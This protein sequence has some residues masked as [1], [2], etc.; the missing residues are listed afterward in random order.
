M[1]A[2][3]INII[4]S[5]IYYQIMLKVMNNKTSRYFAICMMI[6]ISS[7][8]VKGQNTDYIKW[9]LKGKVKSIKESSFSVKEIDGKYVADSLEYY[10]WNEFNSY[11]NKTVDTK[12]L[13]NG[14]S[15]KN[16]I[17]KYDRNNRRSE[18]NQYARD[19]KLIRT[20]SYKYDSNGHLIEDSSIEGNGKPGKK[21][22]YQYDEKW[23]V[24]EDDSYNGEGKLQKK[25]TYKYDT[26]GN[27][28]E[29]FRYN[30]DG[31]LEKKIFYTYDIQNNIVE[32]SSYKPDGKLIWEYS[33]MY[34]YD[35]QNN[36]IEKIRIAGGKAEEILNREVVYFE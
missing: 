17:Y 15:D 6:S 10:Y 23:N 4:I 35:N 31:I 36:W 20:I 16:Y 1:F 3:I 34:K 32:E 7:I 8:F 12:F 2:N 21:I 22:A 33:Y 13:P 30:A 14:I 24:I 18:E 28:T 25:F 29:N 27:K 11:G 5:C 9:N 26:K 19:G